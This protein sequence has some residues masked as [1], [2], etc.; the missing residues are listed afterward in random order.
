MSKDEIRFIVERRC[1]SDENHCV[2]L[3]VVFLSSKDPSL[4]V[5]RLIRKMTQCNGCTFHSRFYFGEYN[6]ELKLHRIEKEKTNAKD[7]LFLKWV[8]R[9]L[10]VFMSILTLYNLLN[11]GVFHSISVLSISILF[12]FVCSTIDTWNS[13]SLST[14]KKTVVLINLFLFFYAIIT[15][16]TRESIE[17]VNNSGVK[18]ILLDVLM[19]M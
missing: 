6:D 7:S 19:E 8:M 2:L 5:Q 16:P 11:H 15:L 4:D 1:K 10:T 3:G 13:N 18:Q 14:W 17:V 9:V 12:F